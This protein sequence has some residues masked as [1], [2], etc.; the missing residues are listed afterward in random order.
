MFSNKFYLLVVFFIAYNTC[1]SQEVKIDSVT[2]L[3]PKSIYSKNILNDEN[4]T[5]LTNNKLSLK[6][7]KFVFID[8]KSIDDGYFTIPLK[9]ISKPSDFVFETFKDIQN[10]RNLEQSFFDINK[11]YLPHIPKK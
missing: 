10:T 7:Y 6:Q 8:V 11:L 1:F 9:H 5:F 3:L 4:S 2:A